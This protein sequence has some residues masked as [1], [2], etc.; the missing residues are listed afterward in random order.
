MG[1]VVIHGALLCSLGIIIGIAVSVMLSRLLDNLFFGIDML[2]M[3]T[4]IA[5]SAT[6]LVVA[7]A[8]CLIPGWTALR[9]SPMEILRH[10]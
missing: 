10:E 3:T 4:T 1:I 7:I 2:D 9:I 6:L 5:V 8:A